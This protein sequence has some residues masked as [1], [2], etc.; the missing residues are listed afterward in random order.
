MATIRDN[1]TPPAAFLSSRKRRLHEEAQQAKNANLARRAQQELAYAE[2]QSQAIDSYIAALARPE[3]QQ[4]LLEARR[5]L[6]RTYSKMT[7]AQLEEL[8]AN[9][10][11][12]EVKNS[13]RVQVKGFEEFCAEI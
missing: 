9:W 1:V 13:G 2:Y 10:V 3:Y 7:D 5:Q 12:A 4:T 11:R 6:K 8:A